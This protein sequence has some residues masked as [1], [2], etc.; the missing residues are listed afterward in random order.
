MPIHDGHGHSEGE[1]GG[2]YEKMLACWNTRDAE[3]LAELFAEESQLIGP[4]GSVLEG[5]WE[6]EVVL[7]TVFAHRPPGSYVAKVKGVQLVTP[8]VAVLRAVAGMVPPGEHDINPAGNAVHALVASKQAG[9][10]GIVLFQN[11]PA[12]FHGRPRM[13]DDLCDELREL[14]TRPRVLEAVR[15]EDLA[16]GSAIES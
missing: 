7:R 10:W 2:L 11:T 8:D 16:G 13:S 4:D 6:I 9:R 14:L 5:R 15:V 12:A 3:T 1:V